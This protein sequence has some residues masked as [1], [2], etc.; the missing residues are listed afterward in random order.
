MSIDSASSDSISTVA[1]PVVATSETADAADTFDSG[2]E[3]SLQASIAWLLVLSLVQKSIGFL[4]SLVV[5]RWLDPVNLGAWGMA[6]AVMETLLPLSLLSIPGCFGRYVEHFRQRDQIRGFVRQSALLCGGC[7]A[8]AVLVAYAFQ[9]RLAKLC[10]G[11]ADYRQ[12]FL[13]AVLC[14]VPSACFGFCSELLVALRMSKRATWGTFCRGVTFTVIT[15]SLLAAWRTDV[16][17]M[18]TAFGTSY[19][20]AVAVVL[21]PVVRA[22]RGTAP[23]VEQLPMWR[24]WSGLSRFVIAF[25]LMD[26]LTNLF[27]TVDRYMLVNLSANKSQALEQV[28]NYES[29]HT[30]PILIATIVLMISRLVLPYQGS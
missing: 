14:T 12:I 27:F 18:I 2:F 23:D 30:I 19:L 20:L 6:L 22:M 24:T 16:V 15:I 1:V 4:R 13:F 10:F 11:S 26:L 25:W 9:V 5:C 21:P 8:V 29:A 17:A 3:D 28:G 7:L